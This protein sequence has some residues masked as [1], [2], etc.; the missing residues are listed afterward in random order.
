MDIVENAIHF[1]FTKQTDVLTINGSYYN[2][3][4]S[5]IFV[6]ILFTSDEN[7]KVNFIFL[8]YIDIYI[9]DRIRYSSH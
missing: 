4:N 1:C 8:E 2:S 7:N 6:T 3:T 9:F 5:A